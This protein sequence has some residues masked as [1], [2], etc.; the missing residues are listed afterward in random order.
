[1]KTC[2]K[3]GQTKD[4]TSFTPRNGRLPNVCRNCQS[5]RR[6]ERK[7]RNGTIKTKEQ[8]REYMRE[9]RIKNKDAILA[10][11]HQNRI[12]NPLR[13][14][15]RQ[16]SSRKENLNISREEFM[17]L[18]VPDVCP[19]LGIPISYELGRDNFPSVDRINPNK[20]Y[21]VGNVAI[22]SYRAN[23]LKS[24]GSA[25]EHE[26]IAKWLHTHN[27][28]DGKPLLW[29]NVT[30]GPSFVKFGRQREII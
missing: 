5:A 13:R 15:W 26:L 20:P 16:V 29:G 21:E 28:F 1:M 4:E 27:R 30:I 25:R 11:D 17:R 9:Y 22:I 10:R 23:M 18:L 24:V 19:A 8:Q 7:Y 12:E 2:I 14:L 3:C 6:A